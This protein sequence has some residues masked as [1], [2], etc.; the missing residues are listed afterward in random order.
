MM[1]IS[2]LK[3]ISLVAPLR[4]SHVAPLDRWWRITC[5]KILTE[6]TCISIT[7]ADMAS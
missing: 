1:M 5:L 3:K 2:V 7:A 6:V 4:E